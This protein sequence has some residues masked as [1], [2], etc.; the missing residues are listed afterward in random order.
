MSRRWTGSSVTVVE[1]RSSTVG[2]SLRTA[3][4]RLGE[5]SIGSRARR[6]SARAGSLLHPREMTADDRRDVIRPR[7]VERPLLILVRRGG[8]EPTC[9]HRQPRFSL[10]RLPIPT[11]PPE[12]TLYPTPPPPPP[13][14]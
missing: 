3:I 2:G 7:R 12:P 11:P 5:S 14:R 6:P 1:R 9:P 4:L 8:L 10:P 13:D